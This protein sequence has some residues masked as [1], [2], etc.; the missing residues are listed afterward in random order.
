MSR[1]ASRLRAV[2]A[3]DEA[4]ARAHLRALLEALRVQIV[5]ECAGGR[6]V[7]P[8]VAEARPDLVCLDVRMPDLDGIDVA[9]RLHPGLPVVFTSG[10]ADYAAEAFEVGAADYVLKPLSPARLGEAMRRVRTRLRFTGG[11]S[12]A[13]PWPGAGTGSGADSGAEPWTGTVPFPRIYI[14]VDDHRVALAPEAIRF[15]EAQGGVCVV[16]TDDTSYRLRTP[17]GRLERLLGGCG[18]LRTHR[19]YLVN[20]RRVRAL[21]PW[22]RHVHSLLLD[23]GQ[24]THLPVAKSRLA[25]F[26]GSV[27]WIPHAG[28]QRSGPRTGGEGGDRRRREPRVGPRHRGGAGW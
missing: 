15:V 7:A 17:L 20:L 27:I 6:E 9:R 14:P 22:S 8:L 23:G 16:H 2:I 5:A 21:V 13:G 25:A 19:A 24:E 1:T 12:A 28:G 3:D 10:Y 26:R 4:G 18:F 11:V